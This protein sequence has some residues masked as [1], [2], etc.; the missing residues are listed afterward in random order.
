MPRKST[1]DMEQVRRLIEVEKLSTYKVA[2][3]VGCNQ[4]H[5]VRMVAKYNKQNPNNPIKKRNKSEAQK[6]YIKQAGKHQRDGTTHDEITKDKISDKMREFYDSEE[7]EAAKDRIR[8]FRQQEWAEKSEAERAAILADL[9]QA[10]RAKMQAGE[11]SNFENFLAEQLSAHGFRV[12]QRTKAWTPGQKFHVDIA[13]PT[14]KI[15]IE[16]DGPTHWAPI[17]GDEELHK[18]EVKDARKDGV[19]NANGWNVLRVQD[20]SG[21]TTRARF[22]RVLDTIKQ[23]QYSKVAPTTWYVRP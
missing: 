13:M 23:V 11:G 19:L 15:I 22:M 6:N 21:S 2:E 4:S 14:E 10:N 5:I 18:V 17:Y 7:G 12:E 1:L 3:Q 16:V 9:Q 20:A 8:E